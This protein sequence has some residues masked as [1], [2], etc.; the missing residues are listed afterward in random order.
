MKSRS[1]QGLLVIYWETGFSHQRLGA[2]IIHRTGPNIAPTLFRTNHLQM[3]P[4]QWC[5]KGTRQKIET[6]TV[7][8]DVLSNKIWGSLL[9]ERAEKG[10][11][12]LNEVTALFPIFIFRGVPLV[13]WMDASNC[14]SLTQVRIM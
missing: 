7:I 5:F 12:G 13:E 14:I 11:G 2:L 4:E 8:K 9:E 10:E 1:W 3:D 6:D